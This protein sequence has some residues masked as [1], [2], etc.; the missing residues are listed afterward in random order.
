MTIITPVAIREA[1]HTGSLWRKINP[2][3]LARARG[4]K[5]TL[6]RRAAFVAV[7]RDA[8]A[9]VLIEQFTL[10]DIRALT[11]AIR[12][13]DP[14]AD[15]DRINRTAAHLLFPHEVAL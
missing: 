15:F 9:A 8:L 1:T 3:Q 13:G 12:A 5:T 11:K 2:D 4:I 10:K 6:R 7:A 14:E